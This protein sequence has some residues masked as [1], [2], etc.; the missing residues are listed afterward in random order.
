MLPMQQ[1]TTAWGHL[2]KNGADIA[3]NDMQTVLICCR[4]CKQPGNNC[5]MLQI[6]HG[7]SCHVYLEGIDDHAQ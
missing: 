4:S 3:D 6:Q 2:L 1:A 5:N 7:G